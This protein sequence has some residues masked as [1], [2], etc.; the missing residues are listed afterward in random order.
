MVNCEYE[1]LFLA[2][3][4]IYKKPAVNIVVWYG[5]IIF[6]IKHILAF[7]FEHKVVYAF[8]YIVLCTIF[9]FIITATRLTLPLTVIDSFI[10][11]VI[12]ISKHLN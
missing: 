8:D 2:D 3:I 10:H 5:K 1:F 6:I 7:L 9:I 11:T 12:L 4:E